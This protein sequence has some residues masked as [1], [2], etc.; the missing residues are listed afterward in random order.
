MKKPLLLAVVV[1]SAGCGLGY[2]WS[3]E[4]GEPAYG[5]ISSEADA[6]AAVERL[7]SL[8]GPFTVIGAPRRGRAGD[9]Y[10]GV[11]GSVSADDTA[12]VNE[13]AARRERTA[14]RVDLSGF[15]P[16]QCPV[17]RCSTVAHTQELVIDEQTGTILYSLEPIR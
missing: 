1:L 10:D 7:T 5:R 13:A 3:P 14:W 16:S 8:S 15:A 4:P 2:S 17:A 9:V 12:R 11:Y 6:I